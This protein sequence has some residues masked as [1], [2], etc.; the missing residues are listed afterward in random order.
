MYN[1]KNSVVS[2][3]LK[4]CTSERNDP[5]D[6]SEDL[7]QMV[8]E[9]IPTMTVLRRRMRTSASHEPLPR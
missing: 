6:V 8:V 3:L 5:E 7:V 4:A 1:I 9:M 2:M